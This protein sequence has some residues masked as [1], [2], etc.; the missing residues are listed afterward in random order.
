[1]TRN[2]SGH[3]PSRRITTRNQNADDQIR[4]RRSQL[5]VPPKRSVSSLSATQLERKRAND[6][7]AQRL[8]RQRTKDRID[9]LEK[10]ITELR[11]ENERLNRCLRQRSIRD[12]ELLHKRNNVEEGSASWNCSKA[13]NLPRGREAPL[14][15]SQGNSNGYCLSAPPNMLDIHTDKTRHL[16]VS[17]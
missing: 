13:M 14:P 11:R 10:Q 4:Q 6:R 12:N 1:M 9:G 15:V 16:T 2:L 17:S 7:E 5:R 3:H 8:I